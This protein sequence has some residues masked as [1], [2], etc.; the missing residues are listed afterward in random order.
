MK[1]K[2]LTILLAMLMSMVAS[3]LMAYD[4]EIDGIYYNFKLSDKTATVTYYDSSD[5]VSAYSGSVVIPDMVTYDG[6]TYAVTSIDKTA[7]TGCSGLT[8]VTIPKSVTSIGSSAFFG[9][10]GL[11]SVTIPE[12][13]TS[14][15]T[16]AFTNC[17]GLTSLTYN[18][19]NCT[20]CG[21]SLYP[22]FP[23]NITTLTIGNE[24]K[25]IPAYAF[26]GCS[27]LTSV[28]IPESVTSIGSWAFSGCTNIKTLD[29][30]CNEIGNWF[31]DSKKSITT[32][33]LGDNVKSIGERAFFGFSSLTSV[34]IPE[35]VTSIGDYAFDGCSGLTSI[36]IPKNVTSI[37]GWAFRDCTGLT[38][39][40]CLS[41]ETPVVGDDTF[42]G[43]DVSNVLLI[44]PDD[45]VQK[46]QA[47]PIWG[48][49]N[50]NTTTGVRAIGTEENSTKTVYDLSG[51]QQT[52]MQRGLNIIKA[53]DGHVRKVMVR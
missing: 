46:Y 45:A 4:A 19:R 1:H 41:E 50:I 37:G 43:M 44:V 18:A 52:K 23:S 49:F 38:E 51:R 6:T 30:N 25:A 8:S 26:Q 22:A 53:T 39:I 2:H 7:F 34:N 16:G 15:G 28:T 40:Y 36:T 27:G 20:T 21:T 5:N 29:L 13:V 11:T 24:V 48:Q 3:Q 14:I 35:N 32:V 9:C 47:H 17:T 33:E 12:N 42:D 10:K 31:G